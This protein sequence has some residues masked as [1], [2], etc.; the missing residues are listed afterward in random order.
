MV[1]FPELKQ[2]LSPAISACCPCR[3]VGTWRCLYRGILLKALRPAWK[4]ES[5]YILFCSLHLHD[6]YAYI[7]KRYRVSHFQNIRIRVVPGVRF[8][9]VSICIY[10][11]VTFGIGPKSKL[12]TDICFNAY[13]IYIYSK[14]ILYNVLNNFVHLNC[15]YHTKS[16]ADFFMLA[17]KSLFV[18]FFL[19]ILEHLRFWIL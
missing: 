9:T 1:L 11:V 18:F 2:F 10:D 5:P 12:K 8:W 7:V 6:P 17:L 4:E 14:I 13:L 19:L 16:N 15:V 3:D